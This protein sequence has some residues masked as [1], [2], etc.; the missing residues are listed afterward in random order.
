MSESKQSKDDQ[1]IRAFLEGMRKRCPENVPVLEALGDLYT[2]MSML[3]EGLEIDRYLTS[4]FPSNDTYWYNLSCSLAL[5]NQTDEALSTLRR[6]VELG[7]ND[8]KWMIEDEDLSSL[9]RH[10]EFAAI[11]A[12]IK[13]PGSV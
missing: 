2:K 3:E 4:R 6:A 8:I 13:T 11:I 7:Y 10:P 1:K 5:V 9:K 12:S